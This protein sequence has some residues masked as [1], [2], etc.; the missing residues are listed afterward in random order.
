MDA[1]TKFTQGTSLETF[2]EDQRTI[3]AV[4]RAIEIIGEATRNIPESIRE[5]YRDVPWKKMA[6]MRNKLIHGYFGVGEAIL[7]G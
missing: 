6:A 2:V 5:K 7:W 3:F 1:I 4:V